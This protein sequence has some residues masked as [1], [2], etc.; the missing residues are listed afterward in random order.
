LSIAPDPR[1]WLG[2]RRGQA[3]KLEG[4][5]ATAARA[6]AAGAGVGWLGEEAARALLASAGIGVGSPD[7]SRR[8]GAGAVDVLVGAVNDPELGPVVGVGTGGGRPLVPGEVAFR[9]AP[10][11]DLDAEE[12]VAAPAALRAAL[13]ATP[14]EATALRDLVLRVA[15]LA[16]A[17]P[18][19]AELELD[20]VRV[21]EGGAAVGGLR[22]RLDVAPERASPKTW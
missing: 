21:H 4:F 12:L 3:P 16:D 18:E 8:R 5:D 14:H 20:P 17:V 10:M 7:G 6:A 2:R 11:T 22:V 1:D 15:A 9:L 19:L 13:A